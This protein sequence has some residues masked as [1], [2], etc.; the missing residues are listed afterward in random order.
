MRVTLSTVHRC[1][2]N[3]QL[4]HSSAQYSTLMR[5]YRPL[6][7]AC[8]SVDDIVQCAR[9][10][11]RHDSSQART[12]EELLDEQGAPKLRPLQGNTLVCQLQS[13]IKAK[14]LQLVCSTHALFNNAIL[15]IVHAAS[16][17]LSMHLSTCPLCSIELICLDYS[18]RGVH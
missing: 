13:I 8:Y 4:P 11:E 5:V 6:L 3:K 10:I 18:P 9:T 15:T 2:R 16:H 14:N 1:V 7:N 12:Q 17:R